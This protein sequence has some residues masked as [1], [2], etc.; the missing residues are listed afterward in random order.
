MVGFAGRK[1]GGRFRYYRTSLGKVLG[2]NL[3]LFIRPKTINKSCRSVDFQCRQCLYMVYL[4]YA[5]KRDGRLDC[6][7]SS[8][9]LNSVER[10][11]ELEG[12]EFESGIPT[13]PS[14]MRRVVV[15]V[16]PRW[17]A[18]LIKDEV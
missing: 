12:R 2:Y 16:L 8:S 11:N 10:Q 6:Q 9:M 1:R 7:L 13:S 17:I 3:S 14:E 18:K 15:V 5:L 4:R